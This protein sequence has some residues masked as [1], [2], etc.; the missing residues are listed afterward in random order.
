MSRRLYFVSALLIPCV[1]V[2]A[3][4]I[5]SRIYW[6]YWLTPPSSDATA[7]HLAQVER[8][9]SIWRQSQSSG[10]AALIK[11]ACYVDDTS[12]ESPHG[13]FPAALI[14]RRLHPSSPDPVASS[15]LPTVIAALD[16]GRLL[17]RGSDAYPSAVDLYG[18]V[19]S[20]RS[21]GGEPVV[22]AALSGGEASNDHYPYYEAVFTPSG[23]GRLVLQSCR[24]YWYDVAGMEGV[25][26]WLA[27]IGAALVTGLLWLFVGAVI[28]ASTW[29][30]RLKAA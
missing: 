24:F 19:V 9:S 7:R 17:K 16:E 12:G 21:P 2:F 8:F 10:R 30:G 6:G 20:G 13:R 3:A 25:A 5:T 26:H 1:G 14:A 4:V 29:L 28:A 23:S 22:V 27:G 18:Y 15:L 11:A